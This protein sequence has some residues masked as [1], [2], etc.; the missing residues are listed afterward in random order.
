M[1]VGAGATAGVMASQEKGIGTG[2]DDARIRVEIN[3]LWFRHD[4][5]VF[6]HVGLQVQEGRVLLTGNVPT[7][8]DR[9]TAVRLAWQADGVKEV[10]N[11]INVKKNSG[12]LDAARDEWIDVRLKTAL[13]LD[14][15]VDAVNYSIQTVNGTVYLMGI[16]RNADELKR[17]KAHAADLSY[18]RRIISYVHTR[19]R[20]V[21]HATS[22]ESPS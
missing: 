7:P 13:L 10:I 12:L 4:M 22:T 17:V 6:R 9:V 2:L 16:A 19:R 5:K 21:Q 18:V 8:D 20:D 11:E 15:D 3:G 1:A 14:R